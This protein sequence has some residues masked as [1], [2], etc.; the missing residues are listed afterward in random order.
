RLSTL[1]REELSTTAQRRRIDPPKLIHLLRGDLDWIVM[2]ALEK[3]RTRRYETANGFALDLRRH[4][5][6]EPVTAR[7]PSAAYKFGK[8][9]RRNKVGLAVAASIA[10]VLVI[11]TGVSLRQAVRATRAEVLAKQRLSESETI[12]KF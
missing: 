12:S 11:A 9:A 1:K 10:A 2:K 4:L 7:A 8:F 6:D 5:N 3:D